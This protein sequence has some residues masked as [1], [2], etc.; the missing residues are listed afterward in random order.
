MKRVIVEVSTGVA[1]YG[2]EPRMVTLTGG[3]IARDGAVRSAY[4]R[5]G[6]LAPFTTIYVAL[7]GACSILLTIIG[8]A[9]RDAVLQLSSTD[10]DHLTAR[11]IFALVASALWVDGIGDYIGVAVLLGI[12]GTILERRIGTRWII[13]IFASGHIIAT[14]LT[15]GSVAL[16][17]HLGLLP[18]GALSRIDVGISYGLAATLAA[19]AGLLSGRWRYVGVLVAW[20]YL[21]SPLAFTYDMTSWGHVIALGIGVAWWPLLRRRRVR[22][23]SRA[24]GD[25]R[26]VGVG[27]PR[28]HVPAGR[29]GLSPLTRKR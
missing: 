17:V 26:S 14:L 20:A 1:A 22:S 29:K 28:A 18:S 4:R 3:L 13:A 11:P 2:W 6:P 7:I 9:R 25:E 12:V 10:V 5:V 21:G 8:P 24:S 23:A 16:G 27:A 19:A 15:E